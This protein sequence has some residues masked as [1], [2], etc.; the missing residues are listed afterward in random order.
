MSY[1]PSSTLVLPSTPN[2]LNSVPTTTSYFEDDYTE[3]EN[4]LPPDHFV[5]IAPIE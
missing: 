5:S 2:F 1:N 3:D 4:A